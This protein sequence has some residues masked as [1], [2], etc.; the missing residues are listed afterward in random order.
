MKSL[1]LKSAMSLALIPA[2]LAAQGDA[3][4]PIWPVASTYSIVAYDSAT[5]QFGAAVQSHYF[6]VA[7]VIWAQPAVGA[8][9]TQS[10]VDF[11]Y[12][13]LG[14]DMMEKGK[15]AKEALDGLLASDPDNQV[16]QVAMIDRNGIVAVHTGSKCIAEA[17]DHAGKFYSCQANLMLNNT[18]W[19]AMA[20]AYETTKGDLA[21]R[22]MAALEAAQR[23]GGD[24]R[25]MESAAM[26]VVA[27]HP[28]GKSWADRIIDV[29][30]DDSPQPLEELKRLLNISRAYKHM[31]KGDEYVTAGKYDDANRE[32]TM[33]AQLD[34]GNVEI[35]FWQA[36]TLVTVG[37]V[38][39]S[40][41]IF[42]EVFKQDNAWRVLVPRLVNADMLPND[43]KIIAEITAQ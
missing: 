17:G 32:Y 25:G 21:D 6:K 7:D 2:V 14:L 42:K 29:R 30:V 19:D 4:N 24:I 9:A 35:R 43:P 31:D 26:L 28:T 23:E 15:S 33:A 40:L 22:M 13:P 39:R 10:L 18:V 36:V 38:D 20:K 1:I 37:Q 27:A 5:G 8:V 34:P 11:S 16:R 3:Q 12:G 41:P